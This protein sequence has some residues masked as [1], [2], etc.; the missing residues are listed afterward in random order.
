MALKKKRKHKA[1]KT[2]KDNKPIKQDRDQ[3]QMSNQGFTLIEVMIA[4]A[5]FVIGFLAVG[6]MQVSAIRGNGGARE[7][8]EAATRATDQLETLIAL[9]YDRIVSGGPLTQGA[10]TVFW[11]VANDTPLPNIKTI[12]VTVNWHDRRTRSFVATYMKANNI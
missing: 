3:K 5:I 12:T 7:A 10:Y 11:N 9:P 6:S 2:I 4:M 8:T 1:V